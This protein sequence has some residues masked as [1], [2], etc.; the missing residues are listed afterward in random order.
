MKSLL[1]ITAALIIVA[2][3]S[4]PARVAE[5]IQIGAS[6]YET[7]NE[8][9]DLTDDAED[10]SNMLDND[11]SAEQTDEKSGLRYPLFISASYELLPH[12]QI[13]PALAWRKR[14]V[15]CRIG[16]TRYGYKDQTDYTLA[17]EARLTY[18]NFD[19][20]RT[21]GRVGAGCTF[22]RRKYRE[23][24]AGYDVTGY[25][26]EKYF[27]FQLS[28]LGLELGLAHLGVFAEVGVGYRGIL[29]GG[30]YLRF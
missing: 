8:Y 10:M 28:I 22:S 18:M 2:A 16:D 4:A 13:G 21:Y 29:S 26:N 6:L 27:N 11:Q 20:I 7:T 15:S 30:A 24:K 1:S 17:A 25:G 19:N 12:I 5:T 23:E 9:Y 3:A 14:K